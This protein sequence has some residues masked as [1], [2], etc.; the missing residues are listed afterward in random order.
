MSI[1]V[2]SSRTLTR[3]RRTSSRSSASSL[4]LGLGD[5]LPLAAGSIA[6]GLLLRRLLAGGFTAGGVDGLADPEL[7]LRLEA[8][9]D[10]DWDAQ[11]EDLARALVEREGA[12]GGRILILR[13]RH[14]AGRHQREPVG[15]LLDLH[16]HLLQGVG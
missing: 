10:G 5:G 16:Q 8:F 3:R 11:F 9:G 14:L 2:M 12:T 6:L 15:D 4:L 7:R 1:W 13:Q